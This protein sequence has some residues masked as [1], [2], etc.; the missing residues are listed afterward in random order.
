MFDNFQDLQNLLMNFFGLFIS[1]VIL[2]YV[3][4]ETRMDF[5]QT[6]FINS[7]EWITLKLRIPKE[8][9]KTPRAMEQIFA[10]F[11]GIFDPPNWIERNIKG[12]V[13]LWMSLET[14]SRGGEIYFYIHAP[15]KFRNL[16]EAQIYG[17]YPEAEIEVTDDYVNDIP[18]EAPTQ[19]YNFIG[20]EMM[21]SKPDVYPI[22][23]YS[24]FES[25][26]ESKEE[27]WVDPL[28]S[29]IE[30]LSRTKEGEQI[31][32]QYVIKPCGSEWKEQGDKLKNKLIGR[33][34]PAKKNFLGLL[35][36]EILGAIIGGPPTAPKKEEKPVSLVATL[37]PGEREVI[38]AIEKNTAKLGFLSKI[39]ILYLANN[40]VFDGS[41]FS[42]VLGA[43]KHFNTLNLNGF[44][45]NKKTLTKIKYLFRKTREF[46][47]KKKILAEYKRRYFKE[48]KFIF[49]KAKTFVLNTE[50]M[51]TIY[52]YPGLAVP[53]VTMPRVEAKRGGPPMDLPIE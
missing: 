44:R 49:L 35:I 3:F 26:F 10:G 43:F 45:V 19:D 33:K 6:R 31:W 20:T 2:F 40:D 38:E 41:N 15:A 9:K 29:I 53:S 34:A 22:R 52:H 28:A 11:H 24:Q 12:M 32:L 36:S 5:I 4:W 1:P 17:Q 42:A 13:Q 7:I 30:V 21:L 23:T 37:T 51:A 27:T 50:E 46:Y 39:R 25:L 47:R 48:R 16:I 18:I 14:I 8:V